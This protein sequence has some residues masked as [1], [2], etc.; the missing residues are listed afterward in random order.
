M[1]HLTWVD[2]KSDDD[3]SVKTL[4]WPFLC[5]LGHFTFT[6]IYIWINLLVFTGG[7]GWNGR[8][9]TH[10]HSPSSPWG[11]RF[12]SWARSTDG[13]FKAQLTT[14]KKPRDGGDLG[15]F[16]TSPTVLPFEMLE[17]FL[18]L[19]TLW[20]SMIIFCTV[21]TSNDM[22]THQSR[23]YA[24]SSLFWLCW[25]C[26]H[27]AFSR[28]SNWRVKR[29]RYYA[30]VI[31]A[32][33]QRVLLP[34]LK[35]DCHMRGM[36]WSNLRAW[37]LIQAG[38]HLRWGFWNSYGKPG[39]LIRTNICCIYIFSTATQLAFPA[40]LG[41]CIQKVIC[42]VS[43][44]LRL[45]VFERLYLLS[46]YY[47]VPIPPTYMPRSHIQWR[48]EAKHNRSGMSPTGSLSYHFQ[49]TVFSF[50]S[51]NCLLPFS[52]MRYAPISYAAFS[53]H[54]LEATRVSGI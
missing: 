23:P 31:A 6:R 20:V 44:L 46:L 49:K 43:F 22:L 13:C 10:A 4:S 42:V 27:I 47:S 33:E 32:R 1:R 40:D 5:C 17:F 7:V 45:P 41:T 50:K 16:S 21:R 14:R 53:V 3:I 51:M 15:G 19:A 36:V 12:E 52:R 28:T 29:Q 38:L 25:T 26:Q 54:S 34:A 11:P 30:T 35:E 24:F 2:R 48:R 39:E 37:F 9:T 18:L 8:I